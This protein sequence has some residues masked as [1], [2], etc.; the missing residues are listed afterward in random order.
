MLLIVSEDKLDQVPVL[1]ATPH[2]VT[3]HMDVLHVTVIKN[4][5]HVSI[6][7]FGVNPLNLAKVGPLLSVIRPVAGA[8]GGAQARL[9]L[10]RGIVSGELRLHGVWSGECFGTG[11]RLLNLDTDHIHPLDL[12]ADWWLRR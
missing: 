10:G 5:H 2:V 9:L 8:G 1:S 4:N 12:D 7:P 6:R 3:T 11:I